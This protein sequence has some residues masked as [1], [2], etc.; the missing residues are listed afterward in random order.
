MEKPRGK[1]IL[2]Y[3]DAVIYEEDL[4]ILKSGTDWLND[5]VISFYFEYVSKDLLEVDRILFIGKLF[6]DS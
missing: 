6:K 4:K 3:H 5:R 2:S 1:L